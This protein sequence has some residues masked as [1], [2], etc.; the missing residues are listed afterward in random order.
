MLTQ[1][2]CLFLASLETRGISWGSG[3][4]AGQQES[5][6]LGLGRVTP[7]TVLG[8][9]PRSSVRA[10]GLL[11]GVFC[12]PAR[13][14]QPG[15]IPGV[16]VCCSNAAPAAVSPL[17]RAALGQG[18]SSFGLTEVLFHGINGVCA[19]T[20][21]LLWWRLGE[22]ELLGWKTHHGGCPSTWDT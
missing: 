19:R 9:E 2:L 21:S 7:L 20:F 6:L 10:S 3:A 17:C 16:N 8:Q 18:G 4:V 13:A 5:A 12:T 15:L 1:L 14:A 22:A 11:L